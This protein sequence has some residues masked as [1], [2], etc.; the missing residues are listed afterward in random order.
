MTVARFFAKRAKPGRA[1]GDRVRQP[2]RARLLRR[3]VEHEGAHAS[4]AVRSLRQACVIIVQIGDG[5]VQD[6]AADV[7]FGGAQITIDCVELN[8]HVLRMAHPKERVARVM[9]AE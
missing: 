2:D 9:G 1:A 3:I 6:I 7:G 5:A 4:R 8:Q